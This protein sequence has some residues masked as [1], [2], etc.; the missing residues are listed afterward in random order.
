MEN[1]DFREIGKKFKELEDENTKLRYTH[2][3]YVKFSE[4]IA[5]IGSQLVALSKEI[6]P[7]KALRST[8]RQKYDNSELIT[9]LHNKLINGSQFTVDDI[10][11]CI[12]S[13]PGYN[14]IYIFNK[15]SQM[16]NVKKAKMQH[17][18]AYKIYI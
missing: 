11:K 3:Q 17:G 16:K 18:K 8:T 5:E 9:D 15:L 7:I 6:D 14:A 1:I 10:W 2:Q 13:Q 12:P 4:T